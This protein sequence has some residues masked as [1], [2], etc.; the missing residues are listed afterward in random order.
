MKVK[1]PI[2]LGVLTMMGACSGEKDPYAEKF[3]NIDSAWA[4]TA[5]EW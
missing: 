4:V 3:T 1:F 2:L 5:D